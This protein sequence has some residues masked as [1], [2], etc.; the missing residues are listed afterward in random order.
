MKTKT[1][2]VSKNFWN[3]RGSFKIGGL[4]DIGTHASLIRTNNGK[5]IF[6]DSLTLEGET[7]QKVNEL[8]NNGKDVESV[9]NLHPFHTIHVSKMHDQFPNAKHYGTARHLLKSPELNWESLKT[10]DKELHEKFSS[11]LE[12]SIPRGVDFISQ[13]E[14]LHFSSVLVYHRSSRTIHVDDTLMYIRLP[15]IMIF[16]GVS[17]PISFHPTLSKV[18]ENNKEAA[19]KFQQWA[20]EIAESWSDAENLCAAHTAS[21]IG[22]KK[23][24]VSIHDKILKALDRVQKKLQS[25]K[26]RFQ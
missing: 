17:D 20:K 13:D 1:I 8:T 5:F 22:H 7:L 26:K 12:F 21:F 3:I 18:L 10:E 4:I 23:R 19:D 16:F 9:L 11:D 24:G 15:K 25:H 2:Q 6:L 14:N